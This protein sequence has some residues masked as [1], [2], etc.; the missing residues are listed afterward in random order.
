MIQNDGR[1][2]GK[3]HYLPLG[4]LQ[5]LYIILKVKYNIFFSA[6]KNTYLS[7]DRHIEIFRLISVFLCKNKYIFQ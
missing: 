7:N 3:V 1:D 6:E 4:S 2:L 5:H